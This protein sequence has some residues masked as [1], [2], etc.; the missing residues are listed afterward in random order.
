MGQLRINSSDMTTTAMIPSPFTTRRIQQKKQA[1][2]M[3]EAVKEFVNG[4]AALHLY[5]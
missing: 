1:A 4:F 5:E 3:H 2:E